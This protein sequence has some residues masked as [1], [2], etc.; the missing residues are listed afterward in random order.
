M[1]ISIKWKQHSWFDVS[2]SKC[3]YGRFHR[4]GNVF[5]PLISLPTKVSNS[6]A[7]YSDVIM[8]AMA[9]QS[10]AS[11]LFT[12]QFI[13]AQIKENIRAPRDWPLCGE[14]TGDR[15]I[16]RTNGQSRG[17]C[18]HL[19]TSSCTEIDDIG[20]CQFRPQLGESFQGIFLINISDH[21]PAFYIAKN[22]TNKKITLKFL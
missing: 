1:P 21:C 17:K 16:P 18:F 3:W 2:T 7:H 20:T 15:W 13:Y 9:S 10:L 4:K 14:F 19:I 6:S 5:I 22:M 11:P 8:G 12:Q